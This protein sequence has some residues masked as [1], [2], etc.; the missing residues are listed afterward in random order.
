MSLNPN[1]LLWIPL[2]PLVGAIIAG[3]FGRFIGRQPAAIV[4][5]LGV[6]IAFVMAA[7]AAVLYPPRAAS[8]SPPRP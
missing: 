4:T 8:G 5:I 7:M 6:A 3:L 1:L 2:L